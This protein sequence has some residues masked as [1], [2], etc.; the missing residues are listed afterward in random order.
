MENVTDTVFR[1]LVGRCASPDVYFTEFTNAD[2]LCGSRKLREQ[3][4][5]RLQFSHEE[6]PLVAQLWEIGRAH[7]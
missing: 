5:H 1:R 7:V 2:W 6:R 3:S 4:I